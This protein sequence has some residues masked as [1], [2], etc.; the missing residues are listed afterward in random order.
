[1]DFLQLDANQTI[2]ICPGASL[3]LGS[4]QVSVTNYIC[5]FGSVFYF[6]AIYESGDGEISEDQDL[7]TVNSQSILLRVGRE[8]SGLQRELTLRKELGDYKLLS[9]L[10]S[11]I[12]A[13][14]VLVNANDFAIPNETQFPQPILL[15]QSLGENAT[16]IIDASVDDGNVN[17]DSTDGDI[18][19]DPEQASVEADYL[20]EEFYEPEANQ[21][22]K[23][24]EPGLILLQ[25]LP[26][27]VQ[28]LEQ[29]LKHQPTLDEILKLACQL[30]QFFKYLYQRQWCAVQ[31]LPTFI[32]VGSPIQ[33]FDLTGIYPLNSQIETPWLSDYCAPEIAYSQAVTGP[34]STYLIGIFLYHALHGQVPPAD[35][36]G[37]ELE[38]KPIPHLNQIIRICLGNPQAR[39][40]L[41]QLLDLLID[42]RKIFNAPKV[43]WQTAASSTL[44]L[45]TSRLKNED[46]YGIR[47]NQPST[48]DAFI[49]A[50]VADGMG[51]MAQGE[52]ASQLAVQTLMEAVIPVPFN[53]VEAQ[54]RWLVSL[55]EQANAIVADNVREGGT[56]LSAILAVGTNLMIAHVGD[57]RIYL[58]REGRLQQLTEDHSMVAMLVASGQISVEESLVHPDRSTLTKSIG[59][60]RTLNEGYIQDLRKETGQ[61]F[62]ALKDQDI[63]ILCSDGIWDLVDQDNLVEIFSEVFDLNI[64]IN[65]VIE[66]V[67]KGE[68]NDNATIVALRCSLNKIH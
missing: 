6:K 43:Q 26:E 18:N 34:M 45:S 37:L 17:H 16:P 48:S 59:A 22:F 39:F 62:M 25:V 14:A 3:E 29:W 60:R 7:A 54:F 33:M 31:I 8:D 63:L 44:G 2:H 20:E 13:E 27:S 38:I 52:L 21:V 19:T 55:L 53:Q 28:S 56:T 46:S 57:S 65:Q 32:Q 47:S 9:P 24:A 49:L 58:L 40:P 51:G 41:P 12:S 15:G 30:C 50:A 35:Y 67:L 61:S 4:F 11:A 1:M 42:I 10:L 68:A 36:D 66:K 64:A 5:R 23:F